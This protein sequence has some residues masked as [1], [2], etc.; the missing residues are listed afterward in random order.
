MPVPCM[1]FTDYVLSSSFHLC[2]VLADLH[3]IAMFDIWNSVVCCLPFFQL[4][5]DSTG[6]SGHLETASKS[7]E[8]RFH[9]KQQ[10]TWLAS[11]IRA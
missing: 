3:K 10:N 9:G 5:G 2:C 4:A 1:I 7:E 6:I 8:S 11:Q